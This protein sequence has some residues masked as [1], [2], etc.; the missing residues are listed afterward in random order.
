LCIFVALSSELGAY[1]DGMSN[2]G[3]F[4]LQDSSLALV[5]RPAVASMTDTLVVHG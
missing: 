4:A 3:F 1:F 2:S 5:Y